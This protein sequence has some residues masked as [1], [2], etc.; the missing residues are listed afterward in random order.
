MKYMKYIFIKPYFLKKK[1]N[2]Y[3]ARTYYL[4]FRD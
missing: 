1:V 4:C 3:P 2:L